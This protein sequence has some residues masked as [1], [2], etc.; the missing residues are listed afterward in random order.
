MRSGIYLPGLIASSSL[1]KSTARGSTVFFK[2]L[3]TA[4]ANIAI[5]QFPGS[6]QPTSE[7]DHDIGDYQCAIP[8]CNRRFQS[9]S[10]LSCHL[11]KS[12]QARHGGIQV[13]SEMAVAS[14]CPLCVSRFTKLWTTVLH[15]HSSYRKTVVIHSA[16]HT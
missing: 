1:S 12:A 5:R 4:V 13:L 7:L 14:V 6:R 10:A 2:G 3:P 16:D 9:A 11:R 15:L 8:N